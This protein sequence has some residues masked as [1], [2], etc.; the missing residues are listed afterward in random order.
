M[1]IRAGAAIAADDG[2]DLVVHD[3]NDQ[4]L[5]RVFSSG[6]DSTDIEAAVRRKLGWD[7]DTH[8]SDR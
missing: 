1:A 5:L 4:V 6:Q 3:R 8:I 7:G 2:V